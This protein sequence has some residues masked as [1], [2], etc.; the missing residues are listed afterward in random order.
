MLS[1]NDFFHIF[2]L[3]TEATLII[4][5]Q[6]VLSS[7]SS[8]Y[9]GIYLGDWPFSSDVGIVYLHPFHGTQWVAYINEILFDSYGCASPQKLTKFIIKRNGHRLFSDYQKQGLANKRDS[10]RASYCLFTFYFTIDLGK[11]LIS[12]VLILYYQMIQ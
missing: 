8:N 9:V 6:H 3:E 2:Q 5:V 7:L 1:F 12:A 10:F 4:K 11:D